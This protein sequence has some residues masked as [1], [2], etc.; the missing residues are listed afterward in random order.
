MRWSVPSHVCE[1]PLGLVHQREARLCTRSRPATSSRRRS[2]FSCVHLAQNLVSDDAGH[3]TLLH[4]DP[5]VRSLQRWHPSLRWTCSRITFMSMGC[6]STTAT[7]SQ[8]APHAARRRRRRRRR[9]LADAGVEEGDARAAVPR[10]RCQLVDDLDDAGAADGQPVHE[11]VL[12]SASQLELLP[13]PHD[14]DRSGAG[15]APAR[16][17]HPDD[18]QAVVKRAPAL[19]HLSP[20]RVLD[21]T[22][23]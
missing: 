13:R 15:V 12:G 23:A 19:P 2:P 9:H 22:R 18:G 8:L 4:R 6:S 20:G 14:G 16:H 5:A 17:K 3:L 11:D 21:T 7:R 10:R 1:R